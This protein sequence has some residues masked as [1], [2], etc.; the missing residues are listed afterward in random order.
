[1][2]D[3]IAEAR[4]LLTI[5]D[6]GTVGAVLGN[7]H[8]VTAHDTVPFCLWAAA[9]NLDDYERAFWTTAA[10]G[11]DID[12]NCAIVGG[13]VAARTG[14]AS[15]PPHWLRSLEPLPVRR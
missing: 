6:P 15:M 14:F 4:K 10:V 12:T 1:V 13:I 11:G 3:G 8:R 7:G 9:K 5:D 2:H